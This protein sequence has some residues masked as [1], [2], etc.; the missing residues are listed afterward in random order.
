MKLAMIMSASR[1]NSKIIRSQ[2]L[3]KAI[4]LLEETEVNM[5]NTFKGIGQSS[6]ADVINQIMSYIAL[7][8]KVSTKDLMRE[9]IMHV[10]EFEMDR[11]LNSLRA[12][13][14]IHAPVTKMGI[15]YIEYKR[16]EN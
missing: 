15:T 11:I 5:A 4:K 14:F 12:S 9:F 1:D 8:K 16:K 6:Q 2:D 7:E 13:D 10:S 3:E